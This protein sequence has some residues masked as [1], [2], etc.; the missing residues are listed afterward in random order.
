MS[1]DPGP[2]PSAPAARRAPRPVRISGP[3]P[4][5]S[6][7]FALALAALATSSLSYA[8]QEIACATLSPVVGQ[9]C[10]VTPGTDGQLLLQGDV[11]ADGS[12]YRGGDVLVD[13]SGEIACAGCGCVA[14]EATRIRCPQTVISPGLINGYDHITFDH[15]APAADTGERYEQ[16]HDWR[17]GARGHSSIS[18]S[19][20]TNANQLRWNELRQL[21]SGTTSAS[22]SGGAAGLIRNLDNA[23][24]QGL[25]LPQH[26][27]DTFPLG[28]SSGLQL[29]SGC[30][31]PNIRS[32]DSVASDPAYLP[33]VGEGIDAV[34]R[35]EFL[36]T[37][38]F[39]DGGEDLLQSM[40]AIGKGLVFAAA[41]LHAMHWNGA[42]LVWSPRSNLRLYGD[43]A[44]VTAA[45]TEGVE[46]ALGTDWSVSGSM[47][48]L[49]ELTC[50]DAF[51][52]DHLDAYFTQEQIW[53]MATRNAASLTATDSKIGTIAAGRVAD[54]AVFDASV[55]SDYDAILNAQPQ[56]VILVV[57]GGR[58]LFGEA[59]TL[60]DVPDVGSCDAL[61]VCGSDRSVC[62]LDDIGMTLAQL[63]LAVSANFPYPLFFCG[64]PVDEPTCVPTRS[65]SV[66]GSTIY[67]GVPTATDADGDGIPDASDS[68]PT[69]F[70]PIRPI[71]AG[72]Q[73]DFDGDL[74]GDECDA[75]PVPEP[76]VACALAGGIGLGAACAGRRRSAGRLNRL[77]RARRSREGGAGRCGG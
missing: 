71:D 2:V 51:N 4:R 59:D 35:N 39:A 66:A 22:T 43:T 11:L 77:R 12:I 75:T 40:T 14:P 61:D 64:T 20:N 53:A 37:S 50:A 36:C 41:E 31:Y 15:N 58:I 55:R 3:A 13:A 16:R 60:A 1:A 18:A 47:N 74:L 6:F 46:I 49:R 21:L 8:A 30:A 48:M 7:V 76:S 57:R 25:G 24:N 62:L 52:R 67:D 32:S 26:R 45:A 56:D 33:V 44:R 9:A 28:D 27:R 72:V 73:A 19:S 42:G 5:P 65:A 17:L 68:C 63:E 38:S 29:A 34:A 69:V 10:A 70:N 54:L 23:T